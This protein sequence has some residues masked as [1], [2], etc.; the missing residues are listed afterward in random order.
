MFSILIG[1]TEDLLLGCTLIKIYFKSLFKH[2]QA[3]A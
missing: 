3:L 1:K 2:L